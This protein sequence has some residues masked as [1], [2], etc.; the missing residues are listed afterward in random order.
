MPRVGEFYFTWDAVTPK[1]REWKAPPKKKPKPR[2]K[3]KAR[4]PPRRNKPAPKK[5]KAPRASKVAEA[6]PG[7]PPVETPSEPTPAPVER[8]ELRGKYRC[9]RCGA[10]GHTAR[11]LACPARGTEPVPQPVVPEP[12][13]EQSAERVAKAVVREALAALPPVLLEEEPVARGPADRLALI[14]ERSRTICQRQIARI[15]RRRI[16][17][18]ELLDQEIKR[19]ARALP[20]EREVEEQRAEVPPPVPF[21]KAPPRSGRR[22]RLRLLPVLQAGCSPRKRMP[23]EHP[24]VLSRLVR[25]LPRDREL[26]RWF[27]QALLEHDAARDLRPRTWGECRPAGVYVVPGGETEVQPEDGPKR[28]WE[29]GQCPWLT[30]KHH[31]GVSVNEETGSVTRIRGHDDGR[32]NCS[33]ELASE[34]PRTLEEVGELE[35]VTRERTRQMEALYVGRLREA[36]L[37]AGTVDDDELL[38]SDEG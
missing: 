25:Q 34:G 2:R 27:E 12:P 29:A 13:K 16:E 17:D 26:R 20:P 31:L 9:S 30:C 15:G 35:G 14:K 37:A 5:R 36:A 38:D 8:T 23:A 6:V 21:A 11:S 18:G 10:V 7:P 4:Q 32:G 19:A 3:V 22:A 24:R 1:R 28:F 33:L